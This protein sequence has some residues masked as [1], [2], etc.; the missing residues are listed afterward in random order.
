MVFIFHGSYATPQLPASSL[1]STDWGAIMANIGSLYVPSFEYQTVFNG[2]RVARSL[3]FCAMFC[4]SLF[5]IILLVILLSVL[6]FTVSDYPFC[7]I[8]LFLWLLGRWNPDFKYHLSLYSVITLWRQIPIF[9]SSWLFHVVMNG[10]IIV[11]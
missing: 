8:K 10:R 9:V 3:V 11:A 7:I 2:V 1:H 5:V 4:R 6:W